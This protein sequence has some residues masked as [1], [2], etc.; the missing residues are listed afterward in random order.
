MWNRALI[1]VLTAAMLIV[2]GADAMSGHCAASAEAVQAQS[3]H[4]HCEDMMDMDMPSDSEGDSSTDSAVCCCVIMS[5]PMFLHAPDLGSQVEE[6][7]S[8]Q[9]PADFDGQSVPSKVAIPPPKA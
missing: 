1:F 6:H 5:A 8:W 9:R 3:T 4:H 2:S 7:G